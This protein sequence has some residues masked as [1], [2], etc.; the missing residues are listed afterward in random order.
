VR[1]GCLWFVLLLESFGCGN[2]SASAPSCPGVAAA[3]Q[4][5]LYADSEPGVVGLSSMQRLAIGAVVPVASPDTLCTGVLVAANWVLTSKHCAVA[6][7]FV[8]SVGPD[9]STPLARFTSAALVSHP[10]RDL[11]LIRIEGNAPQ[12]LALGWLALFDETLD[13]RWI[14]SVA[15]LAGY[16]L[17][18]TDSAGHLLFLAEPIESLE[19]A[20]VRVAG[21]G[22]SGACLGDSGGPL[23]VRGRDGTPRVAGVLSRGSKNCVGIDEYTRLDVASARDWIVANIGGAQVP[24]L[25]TCGDLDARGTCRAHDALWCDGNHIVFDACAADARCGWDPTH[26]GYRCVS[27]ALDTCQ[28]I[29]QFGICSGSLASRCDQGKLVHE[30]CSLCEAQCGREGSHGYASCLAL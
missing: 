19:D 14:G 22:R 23:L 30:N 17:T 7:A 13:E 18:E 29:D 2:S 15:Q 5:L 12:G 10:D 28:G 26:Q 20:T 24:P 6:D 3:K 16:G 4:A 21:H 11:L 8:F 27:A 9:D 1:H 25:A